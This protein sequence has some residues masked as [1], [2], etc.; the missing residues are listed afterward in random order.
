MSNFVDDVD[1]R[2]AEEKVDDPR[3]SKDKE[4]DPPM[5]S[6]KLKLSAADKHFSDILQKSL[7]S[8]QKQEESYEDED[9]LFCLA[10]YKDLKKIP[11]QYRLMTKINLM[12]VV[13]KAQTLYICTPLIA[14]HSRMQ[15]P[16]VLNYNPNN[17]YNPN[18]TTARPNIVSSPPLGVS[19]SISPDNLNPWHEMPINHPSAT[20]SSR[21][22]DFTKPVFPPAD[23][24]SNSQED[25]I[26]LFS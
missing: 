14:S 24:S 1:E 19:R 22:I 15:F 6:K 26:D 21:Q 4:V 2:I 11:E 17:S 20:S 25:L 7:L 5:Q 9:K 16:Y 18:Y 13:Q 8:R 23:E 3:F 12:E 10:L